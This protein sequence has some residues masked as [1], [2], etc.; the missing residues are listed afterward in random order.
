[1]AKALIV[2]FLFCIAVATVV[3]TESAST[4]SASPGT[5]PTGSPSTGTA[6]TESVS[7]GSA[8]TGTAST[9]SPSTGSVS[10]GTASTGSASTESPPTEGSSVSPNTGSP[11]TNAPSTPLPGTPKPPGVCGSN[12]CPVGSTCEER[13]NQ[14]FYCLCR[15]GEAYSH[16]FCLRTKVFPGLLVW[17]K[18]F[19]PDMADKTSK[20]F[21]E[22]SMN[23]HSEV[24]K[25][26]EGKSGYLGIEVLELRRKETKERSQSFIEA[27]VNIV[28]D[29]SEIT[30]NDV[31]VIVEGSP[32]AGSFT[33]KTLCDSNPCDTSSSTCSPTEGSF[34]CACKSGFIET[35][36][37]ENL[38]VACPSGQGVVDNKCVNCHFGYTGFNCKDNTLLIVVIVCCIIGFLL[39]AALIALPLVVKKSKKKSSKAKEEDIGK[40]YQSHSIAKA[41]LSYG[42]GNSNDFSA[43]VKEPTNFGAPRIPRAT[44]N[45]NWD[46]RTNLEM[47]PSNS[48]QNLIPS[49]I[50]SRLNDNQD[51]MYSYSQNRPRN[52]PYEEIQPK[53]NPYSQNRAS[54][55]YAQTRSQTNPYYT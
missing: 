25:Q 43:S 46:S 31:K 30:A 54:N 51:D 36:Y 6:S 23:I 3:S 5:L 42:N 50:N 28:Y 10:T 19:L 48:R 24:S 9:G 13:F 33:V 22:I 1:M 47:T 12:P 4:E 14:T 2:A 53:S 17:E 44:A 7:T 16:P 55:P 32:L 49:G 38:C 27:S 40:P 39:I 21:L 26:F 20:I 15:P 11:Q 52:H 37:S 35:D 41:P 45:S 34:K 18:E 8:S 29:S